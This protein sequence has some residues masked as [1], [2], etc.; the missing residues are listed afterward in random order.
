[1]ELKEQLVVFVEKGDLDFHLTASIYNFGWYYDGKRLALVEDVDLVVLVDE[2]G[3]SL[4]ARVFGRRIDREAAEELIA[5]R[6]GLGEDYSEFYELIED[7]PILYE[8]P[9]LFRGWRLRSTTVW[10]AFLI[11]VLQQNASFIQGWRSLCCLIKRFGTPVNLDGFKT[12]IPP[13]P[14]DVLRYGKRM[15]VC[16]VG[17]RLSTIVGLAEAFIKGGDYFKV[18]GVGSYTRSLVELLAYR[19]YESL[20][21]DRWSRRLVAET[22]RVEEGGVDEFLRRRYGRWTGLALYLYTVVLDALPIT[23]ALGVHDVDSAWAKALEIA[24]SSG[25]YVILKL[26]ERNGLIARGSSTR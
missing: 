15:S 5:R 17:Y 23:K 1:V 10:H 2:C 26:L 7:D 14:N 16:P 21:V 12:I 4:R 24:R 19:R 8:V 25:E 22:F 18:R 9:K 6:L 13:T 20:P 3:R 11:A